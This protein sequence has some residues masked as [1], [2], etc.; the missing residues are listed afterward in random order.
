MIDAD[1]VG[2]AGAVGGL[3]VL[4]IFVVWYLVFSVPEIEQCHK[5][6]GVIVRIEGQDKCV[7]PPVE[8]KK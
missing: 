1:D 5:D 2:I 6:G 8:I 7:E 3:F 4:V